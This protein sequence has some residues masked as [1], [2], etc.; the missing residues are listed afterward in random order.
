LLL[1][2]G[3]ADVVRP[4]LV[5]SLN[6]LALHA[7]SDPWPAHMRRWHSLASVP[8][9]RLQRLMS[10]AVLSPVRR[11]TMSCVGFFAARF[12]GGGAGVGS[13]SVCATSAEIKLTSLSIGSMDLWEGGWGD[14]LRSAATLTGSVRC[15]GCAATCVLTG[16]SIGVASNTAL[17]VLLGI[18]TPASSMFASGS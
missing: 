18:L 6:Y 12:V 2:K 17:I 14:L 5:A 15:A 10:A 11:S 13:T 8:P 1:L 3:Y 9:R 7:A 4:R 16:A